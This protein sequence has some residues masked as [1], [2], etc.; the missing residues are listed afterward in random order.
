MRAARVLPFYFLEGGETVTALRRI[1]HRGDAVYRFRAQ[2]FPTARLCADGYGGNAL[3]HRFRGFHRIRE[4]RDLKKTP[5]PVFVA[6]CAMFKRPEQLFSGQIADNE[7]VV[8]RHGR[9]QVTHR[10]HAGMQRG[11]HSAAHGQGDGRAGIPCSP[12]QGVHE[13]VAGR[14]F[15]H[16]AEMGVFLKVNL[17][18]ARV[19]GKQ[20]FAHRLPDERPQLGGVAVQPCGKLRIRRNGDVPAIQN[21]GFAVPTLR[22]ARVVEVYRNMPKQLAGGRR[23]HDQH[24]LSGRGVLHNGIRPDGLGVCIGKQGMRMPA[25]EHIHAV[26]PPREL[27]VD[28]QAQMGQRDDNVHALRPERR[29]RFA[30]GRFRRTEHGLLAGGGQRGRFL[31]DQPHNADLAALALHDNPRTRERLAPGYGR[32]RQVGGQYGHMRP[33]H[34]TPEFAAAVIELV[35]ARRKGRIVQGVKHLRRHVAF[36]LRIEQRP[37]KFVP[38]VKEHHIRF[39]S[40]HRIHG[41]FQ[42]HAAPGPASALG[43][44]AGRPFFSGPAV[45][46]VDIVG[47]QNR[48][49]KCL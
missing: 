41:L 13:D 49:L 14:T 25:D 47:V 30:Q 24:G 35:I 29:D 7:R 2:R 6:G 5:R 32:K 36:E 15:L 46:G 20:D 28:V 11:A 33:L 44:I 26:H 10:D 22:D 42:A 1:V 45:H 23:R 34:E 16:A 19:P 18:P 27:A 38:G 3:S 17:P 9:Q 8:E 12:E 21:N 37:L 43:R 31:V 39:R 4:P 48:Q 40:A